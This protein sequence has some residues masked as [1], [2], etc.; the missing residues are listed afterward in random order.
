MRVIEARNVN[1]AW[2]QGLRMLLASGM[3]EVSRAGSVLVMDSPVMTVYHRPKERVL[4]DP[5]RDANPF[6][7]MMESLWMLAG[8]NDAR[9][10][11]TWVR[12]FS[13][14]FGEADGHMHGAYG[15]RWRCWW[16]LDQ[17]A[18]AIVKLRNNPLDR[19]VVLQ[20]WDPRE[21]L[22]AEVKDRPCNTT[23]FLRVVDGALTMTVCCRSNDIVWGAYGANAVHMSFL[24]EYIASMLDIPVGPYYQMSNNFHGYEPVLEKYQKS[25]GWLQSP[26]VP[27]LYTTGRVQPRSIMENAASWDADLSSFLVW[28]EDR[29]EEMGRYVN[30]WFPEVPGQM[31]LAHQAFREKKFA[32]AEK[33]A[34]RV[35][36]SDWSEACLRWI[37]RRAH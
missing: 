18:A 27:D 3:K 10:L 7:H 37:Q 34:M 24:Q 23:I 4:L 30:E 32:E 26:Y 12:D 8:R 6:F 36:A 5:N 16:G 33:I 15:K 2:G 19:Q 14:R 17:V 21:D 13:A 9:F 25:V 35:G 1:Y 31:V 20:M 11:D 22:W 29:P 28:V